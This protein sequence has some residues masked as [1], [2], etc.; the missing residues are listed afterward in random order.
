MRTIDPAPGHFKQLLKEVPLD[1][2]IIMINL[3][4]F[5]AQANYPEASGHT[6]CSGKEAYQRYET[7]SSEKIKAAGGSILSMGA[8]LGTVIAPDT[9][10]W[11]TALLVRWPSFQ[12]FIDVIMDSE[13][14]KGTI[15]RTSALEDARLIMMENK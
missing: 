1:Q 5:R 13:Y 11:D 7:A 3:L 8:V 14:Q 10:G 2:P 6:P 12:T 9:E 4:K 15:H